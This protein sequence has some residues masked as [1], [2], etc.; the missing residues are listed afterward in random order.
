MPSEPQPLPE[1][2]PENLDD[3]EYFSEVWL[4]LDWSPWVPFDAPREF[5][6]I[7][8]EPGVYRIRPAGKDFLMYIGET[9]Q[10]LHKKLA[11]LRQ[12]LRRTDIMP[13]SDPQEAAP[14]L[15]AWR[16]EWAPDF[17]KEV[18]RQNAL[19]PAPVDNEERP[20]DLA[21]EGSSENE[22]EEISDDSFPEDP[23]VI[24]YGRTSHGI[25]ECSAAPLDASAAG[26]RGMEAFL[27]YL[28]RQERGESPLCNFGRF[29]PRY[30]KSSSK[31]ENRRGG[32]LADN[33][34]DNPAGF[35]SIP[36]LEPVGK[37]GDPDWMGLEW[38]AWKSLTE[39]N[40]R[41][42]G[43]GAG[44]FLIADAGTGEILYIGQAPVLARR[45]EELSKKNWEGRTVQF[46]CQMLGET[47]LPH[48]LRELENDLIGNFF[49]IGQVVQS[50]KSDGAEG[51]GEPDTHL[52][53]NKKAPAFQFRGGR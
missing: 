8:K 52:I 43:N 28:Y 13:W 11:E 4:D 50:G 37:P 12:T 33:Q 51:S 31:K 32:K 2:R 36:P 14:G 22:G 7:P 44:L 23:S 46:S 30:R 49:E 21:A 6:Y 16:N 39:E 19:F 3:F 27:L 17:E 15:W 41:N 38:S 35:P 18:L 20:S 29:H 47:V 34:K 40:I 53:R 26:R 42:V 5:F 48:N 1:T 10:S 25:Y 9:G 24:G 45:L